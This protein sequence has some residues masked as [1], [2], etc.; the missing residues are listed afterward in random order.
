MA[1]EDV[2]VNKT[3]RLPL[4]NG[5]PK[6]AQIW[7][8]RFRAYTAVHGFSQ[9]INETPDINYRRVKML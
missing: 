5:E 3:V 4:F 1:D 6:E 8:M 9:S 7:L 2:Q